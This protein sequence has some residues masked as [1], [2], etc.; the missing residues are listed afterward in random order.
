MLAISTP[1][2]AVVA[3]PSACPGTLLYVQRLVDRAVH[4]EHE[5]E[6]RAPAPSWRTRKGRVRLVAA[7]V[8]KWM[9]KLVHRTRWSA[10][11]RSHPPPAQRARSRRSQAGAERKLAVGGVL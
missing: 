9:T 5:V 7:H 6:P 4:V 11:G 2:G 10:G 8:R 1:D 3:D